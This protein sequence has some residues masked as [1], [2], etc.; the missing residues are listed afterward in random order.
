MS[1]VLLRKL[2]LSLTVIPSNIFESMTM[3]KTIIIS[4]A[5][6]SKDIINDAAPGIATEPESA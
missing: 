1:L 4:V 5:G 2:G 3:K 6:E